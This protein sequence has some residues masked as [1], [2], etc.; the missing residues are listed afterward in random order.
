MTPYCRVDDLG[1]VMNGFQECWGFS[2]G[3]LRVALIYLAMVFGNG[4]S[5]IPSS[6]PS[7]GIASPTV[8]GMPAWAVG[9]GRFL[10]RIC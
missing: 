2:E 5:I 3:G 9:F 1:F 8:A 4:I 7:A 10:T 6:C